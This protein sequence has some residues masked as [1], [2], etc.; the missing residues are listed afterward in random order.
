MPEMLSWLGFSAALDVNPPNLSLG[1]CQLVA[2]ARAVI[3]RPELLLCDEPTSNLDAKRARR[4]MHLL[5]QLRKLG[6]TVVLAT[7]SDDLVDRYRYP[8]LRLND[9]YLSG[10]S[11]PIASKVASWSRAKARE[12]PCAISKHRG[13]GPYRHRD[14]A[15][16]LRQRHTA[17]ARETT[18]LAPS[19]NQAGIDE[20]KTIPQA[21][22]ALLRNLPLLLVWAQPASAM[23]CCG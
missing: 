15:F 14:A 23:V 1:Q 10:P 6:T 13:I 20:A 18:G 12:G 21:F 16:G 3:A 7:H 22:N 9:G 19:A 8:I 5:S 2:I 11:P 17:V 4:L